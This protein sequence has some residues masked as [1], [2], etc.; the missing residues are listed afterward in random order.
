[1]ASVRTR[2][3]TLADSGWRAELV[4]DL[5]TP[6]SVVRLQAQLLR[7][8][9][10]AT[11]GAA[12]N[13][14]E[15]ALRVGRIERAVARMAGMLDELQDIAW[16]DAT[17]PAL[18]RERTDLVGLA[19]RIAQDR[20]EQAPEHLLSVHAAEAPLYGEWDAGRLER[21]IA[22]LVDNA[23]KYSPAGGEVVVETWR[24]RAVDGDHAAVAVRDR[25]IGIPDA[26]LPHIFRRFYRAGNVVG[27]FNGAGLGLAGVRYIVEQH[28]GTVTV[29]SHD[30]CGTTVTVRLPLALP[31]SAER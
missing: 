17:P 7:R 31:R 15:L 28:G 16:S 30:G 23:V 29:E 27:R 14:G 5:R 11:S 4:H 2:Q 8:V 26:D 25:G 22:N 12:A 13:P 24:E 3:E 20:A 10:N 6:L 21:A 18:Q 19:R 9:A 1:M